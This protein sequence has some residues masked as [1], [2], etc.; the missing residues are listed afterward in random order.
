MLSLYAIYGFCRVFMPKKCRDITQNSRPSFIKW[1]GWSLIFRMEWKSHPIP[2]LC[3]HRLHRPIKAKASRQT[4]CIESHQPLRFCAGG[5]VNTF[6]MKHNLSRA[7][8][9]RWVLAVFPTLEQQVLLFS[10]ACFRCYW[11]E[12]HSRHR[13]THTQQEECKRN[14]RVIWKRMDFH[15]HRILFMGFMA[16][17]LTCMKNPH[18]PAWWPT[19]D[20]KLSGT[21]CRTA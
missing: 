7:H 12:N 17:F 19:N 14:F 11:W 16:F 1:N 6:L 3:F 8:T 21:E 10:P 9:C 20:L 13:G 4:M 18:R 15:F 2:V 5:G